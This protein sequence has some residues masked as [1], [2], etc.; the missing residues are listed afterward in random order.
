MHESVVVARENDAGDRNLVAYVGA[1][2]AP[3]SN[4]GAVTHWRT[5]WDEA[6]EGA[7]GGLRSP[8][9]PTLNTSGWNSSYNGELIPEVEMLEWVEHTVGRILSLRPRRVLEIGCGTGM[10]LIRIAPAASTTT[11]WTSRPAPSAMF[12]RR[13]RSAACGM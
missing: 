9:D 4:G 6:Y 13:R 1:S 3:S 8:A 12:K 5:V 7:T 10:L 11:V 2:S